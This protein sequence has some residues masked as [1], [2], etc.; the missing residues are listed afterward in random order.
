MVGE[1]SNIDSE[2]VGQIP[3]Y[4]EN[5]EEQVQKIMVLIRM[6]ALIM[7]ASEKI[8]QQ[9]TGKTSRQMEVEVMKKTGPTS[10]SKKNNS[11]PLRCK[12]WT[13]KIQIFSYMLIGKENAT[14]K[15]REDEH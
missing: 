12:H 9:S 1:T 5:L 6:R 2:R 7:G 8:S 11:Y 14:I 4:I 15:A 10:S 13:F 3:H